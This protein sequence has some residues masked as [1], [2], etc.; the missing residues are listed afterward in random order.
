MSDFDLSG[1]KPEAVKDNDFEVMTGKNNVCVVNSSMIEKV[2]AGVSKRDGESYEAYTRLRYELEVVS[3]KFKKRKVWKSYNLD[4]VE[5][6]GKK[7]K[8][9]IQ[10]LAD[11]FFTLGLEFSNPEQLAEANEKFAGMSLMVSFSKF[12][13][14]DRDEPLQLHTIVGIAAEKWDEEKDEPKQAVAF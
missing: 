1:Y 6:S 9:P 2:E 14:K 8:T 4:S 7:Q 13:P 11:M 10:K 3:E 5:T 12:K